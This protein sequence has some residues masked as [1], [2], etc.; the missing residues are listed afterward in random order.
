MPQ[1]RVEKN[2]GKFGPTDMP[3]ILSRKICRKFWGGRY[4][5]NFGSENMPAISGLKICW[6]FRVQKYAG[7]FGS[8]KK[9]LAM[10]ANSGRKKMP[11]F[12]GGDK[13]AGKTAIV[14]ELTGLIIRQIT[15]VYSVNSSTSTGVVLKSSCSPMDCC[16]TLDRPISAFTAST[17]SSK[18]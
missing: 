5:E 15:S 17:S 14:G 16:P 11:V 13:I 9:M 12:S 18:S 1:I 8:K 7:D 2:A 10:S 4:A 6:Q 3:A